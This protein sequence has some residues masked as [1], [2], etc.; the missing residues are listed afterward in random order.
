VAARPISIA[1]LAGVLAT[2]C[3]GPQPFLLQGDANA[4]EVGFASDIGTA[5]LVAKQHCARY[6]RVPRFLEAQENVAFFDCVRP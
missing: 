3:A 4:A 6:E 2:G 5:T 1:F